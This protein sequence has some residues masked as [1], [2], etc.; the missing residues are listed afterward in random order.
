MATQI[1]TLAAVLDTLR[2]RELASTN[3]WLCSNAPSFVF[4]IKIWISLTVY[5]GALQYYQPPEE[6]GVYIRVPHQ[7]SP[8]MVL[9]L[10]HPE[11]KSKTHD[12]SIDL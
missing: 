10:S 11:L 4:H 1:L 5:P 8:S 7:R 12:R 3:I 2:A 9:G 6:D